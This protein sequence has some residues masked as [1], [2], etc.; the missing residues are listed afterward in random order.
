M[1]EDPVV[2]AARAYKRAQDT[3]NARR[4]DLVE[5]VVHAVLVDHRRQSEV[6]RLS[7]YTREH[8]RRLCREHLDTIEAYEEA[9]ADDEQAGH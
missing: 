6:A 3:A 7:G 5:A 2:R 1:S 9:H 8:V 4:T